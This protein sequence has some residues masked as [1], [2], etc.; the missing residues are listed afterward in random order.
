MWPLQ[1]ARRRLVQFWECWCRVVWL[2]RPCLFLADKCGLQRAL[3][4]PLQACC[5]G[6]KCHDRWNACETTVPIEHHKATTN[7]KGA[8]SCLVSA[9]S[10]RPLPWPFLSLLDTWESSHPQLVTN[11]SRTPLECASG[12]PDTLDHTSL[13]QSSSETKKAQRKVQDAI[14]APVCS[15]K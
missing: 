10:I 9:A 14:D 1:Q 4:L 3:T 7:S 6:G 15:C 11:D 5:Q 2:G 13:F 8:K 12:C